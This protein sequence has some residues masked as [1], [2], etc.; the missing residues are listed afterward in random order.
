MIFKITRNAFQF[1]LLTAILLSC[2]PKP[3]IYGVEDNRFSKTGTNMQ[4]YFFRQDGVS[5]MLTVSAVKSGGMK[6][7]MTVANNQHIFISFNVD[8]FKLA[9]ASGEIELSTIYIDNQKVDKDYKCKIYNTDQ[10]EVLLL[11]LDSKKIKAGV[12]YYLS[13]GKIYIKN[14]NKDLELNDIKITSEYQVN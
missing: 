6:I 8:Q 14:Y 1:F 5:F 4:Q 9:D 11:A 10:V 12:D 3:V 2:H 13:L 7:M